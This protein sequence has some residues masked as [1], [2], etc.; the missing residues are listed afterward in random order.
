VTGLSRGRP[1]GNVGDG[2][3]LRA[4]VL[5]IGFADENLEIARAGLIRLGVD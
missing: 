2:L 4:V 5:K 3:I 1:L